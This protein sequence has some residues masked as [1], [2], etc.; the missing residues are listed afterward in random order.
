M[1]P[2][3]DPSSANTKRSRF[4]K[5]IS[6]EDESNLKEI[7]VFPDEICKIRGCKRK[8]VGVHDVCEKHGGEPVIHQNLLKNF[9]ITDV[10]MTNSKFDPLKHPLQYIKLSQQGMADVEIAAE[11]GVGVHTMQKWAEKF[12]DFYE[13]YKIGRDLYEAWWLKEGKRNLNNRNYNTNLFKFLTSNKIGFSEKMETKNL[14][15]N[16]GVLM[17]P[18]PAE[19]A[20]EWEADC[21]GA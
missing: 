4:K 5:R 13:A 2:Q 6:A 7:L 17:V 11:F 9:E 16:A 10:L 18:K 20:D 19:C 21:N 12:E 1:A 15:V 14:N 8:A 3:Q